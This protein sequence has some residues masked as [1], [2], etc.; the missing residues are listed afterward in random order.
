M[1]PERP[2][3]GQVS[4]YDREE[5]S[6]EIKPVNGGNP[7]PFTLDNV[8]MIRRVNGKPILSSEKKERHVHIFPTLRVVFCFVGTNGDSTLRMRH[9]NQWKRLGGK[10]SFVDQNQAVK[11]QFSTSVMRKRKERRE[12]RR[13]AKMFF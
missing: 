8:V 13:A 5:R 3:V 7:I 6:G 11:R 9:F 10:G 2:Q 1:T 12:N 4:F